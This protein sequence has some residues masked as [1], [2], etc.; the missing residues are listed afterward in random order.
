MILYRMSYQIP[1]RGHGNHVIPYLV[2]VL[3]LQRA[4]PFREWEVELL[5]T[6]TRG[7]QGI[8]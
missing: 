7:L 4:W 6:I 5:Q 2:N 8:A 1:K 3:I